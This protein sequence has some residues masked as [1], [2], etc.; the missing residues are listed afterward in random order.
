MLVELVVAAGAG[1]SLEVDLMGE[2]LLKANSPKMSPS[3]LMG[4]SMNSRIGFGS[5]RS[6][7]SL[8]ESRRF[9]FL[10]AG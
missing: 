6:Y 3:W 2:G 5:F 9:S 4:L 10:G 1:C 8:G 7:F